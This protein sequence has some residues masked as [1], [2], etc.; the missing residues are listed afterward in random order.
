MTTD[1]APRD[2]E[3]SGATA[4]L[5][6]II[7]L[8]ERI[9]RDIIALLARAQVGWVFWA[10]GQTK[11]DGFA[12]KNSTFY[13][14]REEYKVP[15]ISPDV[16]AYL[17]TAAEHIFPLFLLVGFAS[18]FSATALLLMTLVIQVFVYPSAYLT[19]A[20][21]ALALLFIMANGPGTFSLDHLVRRRYMEPDRR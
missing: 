3:R 16:A 12:L 9:P 14:F 4:A 8:Y 6:A 11:V 1:A 7:G 13:L 15:L 20:W 17:A 5:S 21:W 19:H 10:S 2:M 18:R